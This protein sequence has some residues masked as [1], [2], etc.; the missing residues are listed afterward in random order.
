MPRILVVEDDNDLQYLYGSALKRQGY[1]VIGVKQVVDAILYLT[2]EDFNLIILDMNLPDISGLKVVEFVHD[3]VRLK[4]I[5]I[6]VASATDSYR[7][8]VH[9]LGIRHYL[10]KPT[11][12]HELIQLVK[13]V[14]GE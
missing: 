5:P 4:D 14:L 2:A 7:A 3:D 13:T 1:E 10:I 12:L 8:Q 11:P 6:I 9:A